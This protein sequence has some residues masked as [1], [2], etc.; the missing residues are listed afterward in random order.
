MGNTVSK[1]RR[2]GDEPLATVAD[3]TGPEIE[4]QTFDSSDGRVVRASASGAL[5]LGLIPSQFTASL[6][7]AQH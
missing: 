5:D 6:L 4:P 1:E 3:L 2:C 7:D